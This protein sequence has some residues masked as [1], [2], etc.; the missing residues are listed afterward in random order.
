MFLLSARA[1]ALP[2]FAVALAPAPATAQW[3]ATAPDTMVSP[4]IRGVRVCAGG[5]LTLGTNL[6]TAW[7]ARA[8][9][10]LKRRVPALPAPGSLLRPLIPLV[11]DADIVLLNVESAIG[12]GRTTSKCGPKSTGCY[13]LRAPPAAARAIRRLTAM[14]VVTNVA[15]NHARDAGIAGF[16]RTL[17]L[18]DSAGLIVTGA[19]TLASL[20]VTASGDTVAFLGFSASA[21]P[22]VRDLEA[23]RRHVSR[24][25]ALH[26]RVVVT[27]HIGAEGADAQR[28]RDTTEEYY[29]A[30][31]GNPVAFASAA[32]ESGAS[33]VFGHGP[34]VVRAIEWRNNALIFYSLGN[35][36]TYGP[37]S[38]GEPMRRGVVACATIDSLGHVVE[39]AL[40]ATRQT[41][42][43]L[44]SVDPD[45]RAVHLADSLS[46][47]DF[48]LTRALID[49]SGRISRQS[50]DTISRDSLQ[51]LLLPI[52]SVKPEVAPPD[53][54]QTDELVRLNAESPP[55]VQ[56]AIRK[57]A[58]RI[59]RHG[60]AVHRLQKEMRERETLE[61]LRLR[62]GFELR[63]D[64]FQLVPREKP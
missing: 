19:D 29:G 50:R 6:D 26:R 39:A 20:A 10:R 42:P 63:V 62:L 11:A 25:A 57:R 3:P 47:L 30:S 48:P 52:D 37:F 17:S 18:L 60:R 5:D 53:S 14:P 51:R 21:I 41:P 15:N 43:G 27:A 33:A 44:L 28:T 64:E 49:S 8:T 55:R 59:L 56:K 9:V 46:R 7:A 61:L 4:A 12:S 2:A 31:R 40:R 34:H 13:A 38:F 36:L 45:R 16:Q 32:V 22:D 23:V 58:L 24:A 35:L 54:A 1:L